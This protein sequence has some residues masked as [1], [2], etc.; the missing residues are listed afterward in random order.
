MPWVEK[1]RSKASEASRRYGILWEDSLTSI[2][3]ATVTEEEANQ[4]D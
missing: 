4:K 1:A 2:D 3:F